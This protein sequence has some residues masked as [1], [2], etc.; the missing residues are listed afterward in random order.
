[1]IIN[2]FVHLATIIYVI[3][4]RKIEKLQTHINEIMASLDQIRWPNVWSNVSIFQ[5]VCANLGKSFCCK[6]RWMS[7]IVQPQQ[8]TFVCNK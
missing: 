4:R 1:M 7:P 3:T 5:V 8:R 2:L 6:R